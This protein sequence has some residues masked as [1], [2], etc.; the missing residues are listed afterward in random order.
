MG[1]PHALNTAPP[2]VALCGRAGPI[3]ETVPAPASTTSRAPDAGDADVF[4]VRAVQSPFTRVLLH[5]RVDE[6]PF[7]R[8][9]TGLAIPTHVITV[10]VRAHD[11]VDGF[12]GQEVFLR[13]DH[14]TGLGFE[15]ISP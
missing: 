1:R 4:F 3:P 8:S 15:V 7:S 9:Q 11:L 6:Q 12:G 13:L 10:S 14:P 2:F 5:P